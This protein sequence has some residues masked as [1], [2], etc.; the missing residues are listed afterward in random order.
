[1]IIEPSDAF[2]RWSCPNAVP[3]VIA[4]RLSCDPTG[5][6]GIPGIPGVPGVPGVS[7]NPDDLFNRVFHTFC[8]DLLFAVE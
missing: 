4:G 1:M 8:E 5:I 6:P 7:D 3:T 2:V